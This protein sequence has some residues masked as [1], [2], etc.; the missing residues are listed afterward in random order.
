MTKLLRTSGWGLAL[1]S[2]PLAAWGKEAAAK[3][4][5]IT[6]MVPFL[7]MIGIFYFLLIRPQ[8]TKAKKHQDFLKTL[9]RG[10]RVLTNSGIFGTVEGLNDNFVTLE[11]S[12][13]VK[14]RL[15]RSYVAQSIQEVSP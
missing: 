1:I 15:L 4:D 7:V 11:V 6:Q 12:N 2:L 14:I 13:G 10:D 3:P 9:K 5:V 8:A